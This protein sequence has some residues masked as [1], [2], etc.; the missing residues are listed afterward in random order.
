MASALNATLGYK[1]INATISAM[2]PNWLM[3]FTYFV[4]EGMR[5]PMDTSAH[6][7][8]PYTAN[9]LVNDTSTVLSEVSTARG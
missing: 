1:T 8:N 3:V 2:L 6:C 9:P 4:Q 7:F 5:V